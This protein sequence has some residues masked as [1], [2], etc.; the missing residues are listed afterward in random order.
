MSTYLAQY[1]CD[2]NCGYISRIIDLKILSLKSI[3]TIEKHNKK[4]RAGEG[5]VK[6]VHGYCL[7]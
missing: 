7:L 2:V 3:A 1:P 4:S 6:L 5:V